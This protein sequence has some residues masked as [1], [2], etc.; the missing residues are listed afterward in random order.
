MP[1]VVDAF[2][3]PSYALVTEVTYEDKEVVFEAKL[4]FKN[5]F[6]GDSIFG[7]SVYRSERLPL[8]PPE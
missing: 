6:E 8:Y 4:E 3:R 2:D 7:D 5:T 1:G